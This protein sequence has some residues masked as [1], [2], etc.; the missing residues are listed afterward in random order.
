MDD[1]AGL[2]LMTAVPLV[3][4]ASVG[5]TLM[6]HL[7]Y[8][9]TGNLVL[10]TS[11]MMWSCGLVLIHLILACYFW[12]LIS[13]KLPSQQLIVSGFLPLAPLGQ[14]AYAALQM[15]VYLSNY[16]KKNGFAPTQSNPPPLSQE[17]LIATGEAIHWFGIMITLFLLAE[18]TFWLVQVVA[19]LFFV[20][21]KSFNIGFWSFT[22]P[23]ASYTNAWSV[24]SRDLRNEGM[25]GWAAFC[26]MVS[27]IVWLL[28]ALL[29]VYYGFWKGALFQAPGLEEWVDER[30]EKGDTEQDKGEGKRRPQRRGLG[31]GMYEM[32]GPPSGSN[33]AG[34]VE[35]EHANGNRNDKDE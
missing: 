5:A 20:V 11:F 14:G 13:F 10:V 24:L 6:G 2:W 15:S 16:L 29:T 23:F 1:I 22:F 12:R 27:V 33:S 28:C 34:D 25:R 8:S 35:N 3:I 21:P 7:G 30:G 19:S 32:D 18:A 4:V 9:T 26:T 31:N 17:V